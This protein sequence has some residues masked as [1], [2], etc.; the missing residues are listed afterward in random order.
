VL[1]LSEQPR[2]VLAAG[3]I[4]SQLR[5][6]WRSRSS[7]STRKDIQLVSARRAGAMVASARRLPSSSSPSSEALAVHAGRSSVAVRTG[8]RR[9]VMDRTERATLTV[10]RSEKTETTTR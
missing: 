1:E 9:G 3:C 4:H 5:S 6:A 8:S 10:I 7:H 2:E